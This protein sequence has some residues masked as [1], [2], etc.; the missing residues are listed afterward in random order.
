MADGSKDLEIS[1]WRDELL[2]TNENLED[3]A[4]NRHGS[5]L[6]DVV[7]LVAPEIDADGGEAICRYAELAISFIIEEAGKGGRVDVPGI[8]RVIEEK[9]LFFLS[10]AIGL[11]DK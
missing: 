2:E 7:R 5:S 6:L 1:A 3:S 10:D 11:R 9:G 4:K 8:R